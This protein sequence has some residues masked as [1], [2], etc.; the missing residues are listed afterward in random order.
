MKLQGSDT[1]LKSD[2]FD[3]FWEIEW[4]GRSLLGAVG[5]RMMR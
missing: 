2:M 1:K 4:L 5:Q 3:L